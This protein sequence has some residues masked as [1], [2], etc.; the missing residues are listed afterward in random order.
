MSVQTNLKALLTESFR[1]SLIPKYEL[2]KARKEFENAF[3]N[4]A[5]D[6][7]QYAKAQKAQHQANNRCAKI[8]RETYY[9]AIK[10]MVQAILQ[11]AKLTSKTS[12]G[13]TPYIG[14]GVITHSVLKELRPLIENT[15]PYI[16]IAN[17]IEPMIQKA[18][19]ELEKEH[20]VAVERPRH[21]RWGSVCNYAWL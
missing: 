11:D 14:L 13:G 21:R 8:V 5:A 4:V 18:L 2:C 1:I 10:S 15:V 3:R 12:P 19:K 20:Q 17:A 16:H 6:P 9:P 7:D